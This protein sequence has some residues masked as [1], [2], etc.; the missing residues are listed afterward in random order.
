ML[1]RQLSAVVLAVP[2]V[3][4]LGM[5]SVA[6][7]EPQVSIPCD[8]TALN[9]AI[10]AAN[11]NTGPHTI[12]LAPK[13]VYNVTTPA[14]TGGL[15]DNALPRIT[16]TVT[17]LGHNT[18]IRRD[19]DAAVG[20]RIAEIDGPNGHLTVDGV[21]ATGGG[22][23]DYAGTYLPTDGGTLILRHSTVTNS[24]ANQ[25]GA[26]FVNQGSTLEVHDSVLRDSAAQQGGAIYNGPRSTTLLDNT[27]VERNQATQFGGGIFT[28]GVSLTIKKSYIGGNR[29]FEQGGGIYND[30]APMTISSTAIADNRAG[31]IGGG[32]ANYGTSTLTKTVVRHNSALNGGGIW[33]APSPS[34]LNLVNSRIVDNTPNN[35]RPVGSVPGCTS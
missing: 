14:S 15:G 26:I 33:Q 24:T 20:F 29:A 31:Q 5:G 3:A 17:L 27:K 8:V 30:R 28:A 1:R 16:G 18:T 32:I 23:L 19:P 13:C 7:A 21:T 22:Y 25:G 35:C 2:I 10:V 9:N 11:N 34:V 4:V 6:S 12:R